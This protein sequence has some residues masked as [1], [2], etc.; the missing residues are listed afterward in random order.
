MEKRL[1]KL[2]YR[3]MDGDLSPKERSRLE[4]ALRS[5]PDLRR[6]KTELEG[7]RGLLETSRASGFGPGFS[8]RVLRRI[9]DLEK[10]VSLPVDSFN[11]NMKKLFA[12]IAV[13]GAAALLA[14]TLYNLS[15]GDRFSEE[16]VM[17]ASETTFSELQN[18]PLFWEGG[19]N[20]E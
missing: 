6:E 10:P 8:D 15:V 18:L 7:M 3:S 17:F 1:K 4:Q 2:L 11:A 5:S 12:R 14:L 9:S 13:A 20:H 19:R 16:E